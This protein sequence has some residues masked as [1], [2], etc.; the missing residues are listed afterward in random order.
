MTYIEQSGT[1]S[2]RSRWPH[3]QGLQRSW[4][5]GTDYQPHSPAWWADGALLWLLQPGPDLSD[6]IA[7]GH[8]RSGGRC[9]F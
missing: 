6:R 5:A 9:Q 7:N 1:V 8:P 2:Y 4:L 3:A